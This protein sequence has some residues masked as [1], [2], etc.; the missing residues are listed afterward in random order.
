MWGGVKRPS[1]MALFSPFKIKGKAVKSWQM[2]TIPALH[3]TTCYSQLTVLLSDLWSTQQSWSQHFMMLPLW[4]KF[5]D[6]AFWVIVL[7]SFKDYQI[8]AIAQLAD[9][10]IYSCLHSY[11]NSLMRSFL[12]CERQLSICY[13]YYGWTFFFSKELR[14][15]CGDQ[16]SNLYNPWW[17]KMM[18][19]V[20]LIPISHFSRLL[21]K[22]CLKVSPWVLRNP[23]KGFKQKNNQSWY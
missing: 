15:L 14:A 16:P 3:C 2:A 8:T 23:L 5:V 9:G 21:Y 6:M 19:K 11:G 4:C 18:I 10:C 1:L 12:E 7:V 22:K 17:A 13:G 20:F